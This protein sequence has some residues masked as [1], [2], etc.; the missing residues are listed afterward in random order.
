MAKNGLLRLYLSNRASEFDVYYRRFMVLYLIRLKSVKS[1]CFNNNFTVT[2]YFDMIF[3]PK[4]AKNMR[5][6]SPFSY[7]I[8][9]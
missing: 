8:P 2:M 4:K 7:I 3:T 1:N 9:I 5:P 6:G